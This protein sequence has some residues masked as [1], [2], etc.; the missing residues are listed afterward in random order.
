MSERYPGSEV[1]LEGATHVF[2]SSAEPD[3]GLGIIL[4]FNVSDI[5]ELRV[6]KE[7][8]LNA[9]Y[10]LTVREPDGTRTYYLLD[11]QL[12]NLVVGMELLPADVV[13]PDL[14]L[15]SLW[16]RMPRLGSGPTC[17]LVELGFNCFEKADRAFSHP[18]D[19]FKD[20]HLDAA[21]FVMLDAPD[22]ESAVRPYS[23]RRCSN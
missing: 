6:G 15:V 21:K 22:D 14:W 8:E 23:S 16:T 3:V 12:L 7:N 1:E 2:G 19:Y 4:K 13:V 11:V 5:L 17:C 18:E 9:S 20:V 10:T